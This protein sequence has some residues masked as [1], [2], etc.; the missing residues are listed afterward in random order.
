M[1]TKFYFQ[2]SFLVLF[3]LSLDAQQHIDP[4]GV[5]EEMAVK[6]P[7]KI[8]FGSEQI[9]FNP[10]SGETDLIYST[11]HST[12]VNWLADQSNGLFEFNLKLPGASKVKKFLVLEH[13]MLDTETKYYQVGQS[14]EALQFKDQI[15]FYKGHLLEDL[16]SIVSLTITDQLMIGTINLSDG[17]NYSLRGE[18]FQS[19]WK[20]NVS[21][22]KPIG[23]GIESLCGT[24]DHRHY[25]ESNEVINKRLNDNCKRVG[26][27]VCVD[28]DLY[29]RMKSTAKAIS[30][31]YGV[32]NGVHSIYKK[33]NILLY[34]AE[35]KINTSNDGYGHYS[36]AEDLDQFK[37][38]YKTYNGNIAILMCGYQRLGKAPLGGIAY[39]NTLCVKS[40]SYAYANVL[41]SFALYP[42]YSWDVFVVAHELGHVMGSRHTHACVWGPNKN[43]AID[44]CAS[45]EGSCSPGQRPAK[46]TIMSY[47][48][49]NGG[50]GID[51]T[52]GFGTEPGDV[53]RERVRSS[54][55]L[56]SYVPERKT[57]SNSDQ[58][59]TANLECTDGVYTHYFNDLNTIDPAD[60]ILLVSINKK[61][62][63][64]GTLA[65]G[66]LS[67][68]LHS[69]PMYGSNNAKAVTAPYVP[70][71]SAFYTVNKYLEIITT[72]K[73]TVAVG[74][75]LGLDQTDLNELSS[76][77]KSFDIKNVK[78]LT[79][80]R[81]ANPN[82]EYNH[83]GA[84]TSLV[85]FYN[86]SQFL[87][88]G[89]N[90]K[91]TNLTN[92]QYQLEF[93]TKSIDGINVGA[94]GTINPPLFSLAKFSATK[95]A[96]SS[97]ISWTVSSEYQLSKYIIERSIDGSKFDS[98]GQVLVSNKPMPAT[99]NFYDSYLS[100]FEL[101]YRLRAVD[102]MKKILY[103][104]IVSLSNAYTAESSL[105]IYPNPSSLDYTMIE[106]NSNTVG[107][108]TVDLLDVVGYR[109][110]TNSF[111]TIKGKNYFELPTY[112][113]P[114][115]LFTVKIYNQQEVSTGRLLVK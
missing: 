14:E 62:Q 56:T 80:N 33:E 75:K 113:L 95:T 35:I 8:S 43:Q 86:Y 48:Y 49:V 46:G 108:F 107:T 92:G 38:T 70:P 15:K 10:E 22:D 72:K 77:V 28:F 114:E 27:S 40:Y 78:V 23:D 60:D 104:P 71:N 18:R 79:M 47:C 52:I 82:P 4:F 85:N 106:F 29:S 73:P 31:V 111:S 81:P 115:G 112:Q 16:E 84:T 96:A 59:L 17:K 64:I 3:T 93:E 50:P 68:V 13:N 55:C 57:V 83:Q 51:F 45:V 30:Y 99:Y 26:I 63:N 21:L 61:S 101:Y 25:I 97:Q 37:R 65:D 12:F 89:S 44:N 74:I 98:I 39:I 5:F 32:F 2:L 91:W 110:Y 6:E 69:T 34:V 19:K 90:F 24:D 87:N 20:V 76:S 42:D 7:T 88:T 41:G 36:A 109:K 105:N 58:H 94:W 66:S 1:A 53:I 100:Q 11:S 102:Q 67:I 54:S 9:Q 103:S